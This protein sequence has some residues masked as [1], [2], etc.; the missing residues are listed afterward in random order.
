[1]NSKEKQIIML[2]ANGYEIEEI[3][4]ITFLS[5]KSVDHYQKRIM[6]KLNAKNMPEA[7]NYFKN[8][9]IDSN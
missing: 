4:Q 8:V 1:M 6:N 3:A 2:S 9:F 7:V 5:T